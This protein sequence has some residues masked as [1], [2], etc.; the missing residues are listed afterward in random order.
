MT[1]D[2]RGT[3]TLSRTEIA[4]L[5][6]LCAFAAVL[7]LWGLGALG[8]EV[9]EGVQALAVQG[10]LGSGLPILP[11]GIMYQRAI[12]FGALQALAAGAIGLDEIALRLPAALFGIVSVLVTFAFARALFDRRIAWVAA[13]FIALSG[14]EIELSR[15]ARFYTAFQVT[16]LLALLCFFRALSKG[17]RAWRW[18][19]AAAAI[20]AMTFHEL[21]IVLITCFAVPLFDRAATRRTRIFA[22][23]SAFPFTV[24]WLAY[25]RGFV[26]W[27]VGLAPP[28]GLDFVQ[29]AATPAPGTALL[30]RGVPPLRIP[31]I[32]LD[33]LDVRL[34]LLASLLVGVV[35]AV[36]ALRQ[37][38]RGGRWSGLLLV[39]A[40]A[41]GAVHQFL[42]AGF[43]FFLF[44]ALSATSLRDMWSRQLRPVVIALAI[45]L[46]TWALVLPGRLEGDAK[47]ITLS[48]FGFPNVL[49]YFV[50][51]FA[52]GW[53]LFL[54]VVSAA[55]VIMFERFL[56]NGDRALLF[57]L[58]AVAGPLMIASM[59][60]AYFESRYVFHLYPLLVI[61]FAWGLLR[62][63]DRLASLTMRQGAAALALRG[64]VLA[65]GF[66]AS[67]DVGS[68]TWAPLTRS[69]ASHR[70]P[71]RS[72]ISWKAYASFHQDQQG[73]SRF[74]LDSAG[75]ADVVAAIGV[76]H[77][78]AVYRFYMGRLDVALSRPENHGYQR[79]RNG[80]IIDWVTGSE[81]VFDP[82][83]LVRISPAGTTW[84]VGDEV[85][86]GDVAAYF[87][88]QVRRDVQT[89]VKD[90][91]LTGRDGVSFARRLP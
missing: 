67:G 54:V 52:L 43:V 81:L 62:L 6:A 5:A 90:W 89:I 30:L 63:G 72:I 16:Y 11:S 70:D 85:I 49:Q 59:F 87:P 18:A 29:S 25:R 37:T 65:A 17:A 47:A 64:T 14:W 34:A 10:W 91:T 45:M 40:L 80:K 78:L 22:L 61:L 42:A 79:Q 57:I 66:F 82:K 13:L 2:R 53:P 3:P 51:W 36:S 35:A 74:V 28:H 31:E 83:E 55:A 44:L 46:A 58:A 48:L 32:L 56:R 84:L 7:R 19:F 8:L 68:V 26:R 41:L 12:P 50:Y 73:P 76:P 27:F 88:A 38:P 33:S 15:Y 23:A 21:A 86:L 1:A 77:Q 75:P 60:D 71:I 4:A 20:A 9:D 24:A 69:Y 39:A